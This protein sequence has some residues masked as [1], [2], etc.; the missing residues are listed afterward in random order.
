MDGTTDWAIDL[1]KHIDIPK[2]SKSWA[3]FR[4]SQRNLVAVCLNLGTLDQLGM[5]LL[6]KALASGMR[7]MTNSHLVLMTAS[8][9]FHSYCVTPLGTEVPYGRHGVLL[10]FQTWQLTLVDPSSPEY[11]LSNVHSHLLQVK[12]GDGTSKLKIYIQ[13][14]YIPSIPKSVTKFSHFASF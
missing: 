13:P 10:L 3:F 5:L 6:P 4:M 1:R 9:K 8:E 7:S 14:Q 12:L 2:P 11:R